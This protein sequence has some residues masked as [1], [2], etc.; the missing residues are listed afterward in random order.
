MK[1]TVPPLLNCSS[2]CGFESHL[3]FS[4]CDPL[5]RVLVRR[6]RDGD[7]DEDEDGDGDG[8][9]DMGRDGGRDGG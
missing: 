7:G 8:D 5:Q 3:P 6:L 1:S 9:R 2:Y 4:M